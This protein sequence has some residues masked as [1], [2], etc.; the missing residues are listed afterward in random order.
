MGVAR[1]RGNCFK[2]TGF[3]IRD[4]SDVLTDSNCESDQ[5]D[6]SLPCIDSFVLSRSLQSIP[7][8]AMP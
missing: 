6:A 8:H 3:N 5:G 2:L 4:S 7:C 1:V